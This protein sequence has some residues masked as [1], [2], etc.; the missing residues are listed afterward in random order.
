MSISKIDLSDVNLTDF[1][2]FRILGFHRVPPLIGRLVHIT[3]DIRDVGTE[4][5]VKTFFISPGKEKKT[6]LRKI[7]SNRIV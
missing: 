6:F 1:L 4:D 7:K 3:R 2:F 5:L